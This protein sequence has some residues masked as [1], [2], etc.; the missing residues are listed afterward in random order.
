MRI[1]NEYSLDNSLSIYKDSLYALRLEVKSLPNKWSEIFETK[2]SSCFY[3]WMGNCGLK[4][5]HP[6]DG[7]KSF[8][9]SSG[10]PKDLD[11]PLA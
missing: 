1:A 7:N 11:S 9:R 3:G 8:N 5:V 2:Y 4:P 6:E 10:I